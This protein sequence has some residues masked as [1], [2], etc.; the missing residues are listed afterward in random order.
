MAS[1]NALMMDKADNVV[2]CVRPVK[3][4]EEVTY[5]CGEETLSLTDRAYEK[6]LYITDAMDLDDRVPDR[7]EEAM[8][9]LSNAVSILVEA[10]EDEE[11]RW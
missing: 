9:Y 3:A 7:L 10:V 1:V 2:T 11:S 5:R 4:G 8:E 6:L